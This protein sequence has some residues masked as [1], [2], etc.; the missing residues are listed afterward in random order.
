MLQYFERRGMGAVILIAAAMT[1]AA[2]GTARHSASGGEPAPMGMPAE[3]LKQDGSLE[4]LVSWMT[5]SFSSAEQAVADSAFFDIRLKMARIWESRDDAIWLYVEQAAASALDQPYRQRVYR[6]S[7]DGPGTYRSAVFELP[8]PSAMV[9]AFRDPSRLD[10]LSPNDLIARS[11]CEIELRREGDAYAG[12][13]PGSQCL[14]TLRGAS[15]ATSEVVVTAE[16]IQSWDRGWD[17]AGDQVW[18]AVKG[19]YEFR[20]VHD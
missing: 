20:K 8:D 14:S 12:S 15:Y 19:A 18:G 1:M 7:E 11:G 9:G 2:C 4:E 10:G 17:D 5:G 13:T 16:G 6:V 3:R